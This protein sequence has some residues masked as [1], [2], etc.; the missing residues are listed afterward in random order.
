MDGDI[1][2]ALLAN[3][4]DLEQPGEHPA[5]TLARNVAKG[6]PEA[7]YELVCLCALLF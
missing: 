6:V 1:L 4:I 5:L 2:R 3:R 7:Q